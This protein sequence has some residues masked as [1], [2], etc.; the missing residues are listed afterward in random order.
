MLESTDL[1]DSSSIAKLAFAVFT[2]VRLCRRVIS[3]SRR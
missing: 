3:R 1:E 2:A